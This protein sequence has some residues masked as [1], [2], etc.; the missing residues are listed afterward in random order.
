MKVKW[1]SLSR[2][3][4]FVT[5]V[6]Y[7]VHGIL[8]ASVLEWVAFPFSNRSFQPRNRT[9]V[10]HIAGGFFTSWATREAPRI[11]EWV[12]YPFS[13]GSSQPRNQTKVSCIA[14]YVWIKSLGW[15]IRNRQES[16]DGTMTLPDSKNSTQQ[17]WV[18]MRPLTL[19]GN[20]PPPPPNLDMYM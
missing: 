1:S 6:E 3:Q 12:A 19:S 13:N 20:P 11:L 16:C 18:M 2:V 5:P 9:Q 17:P 7:R 10:S 14:S 4:L 8:Q 15:I